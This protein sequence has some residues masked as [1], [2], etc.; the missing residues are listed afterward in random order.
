MLP[1]RGGLGDSDLPACL[2]AMACG[3]PGRPLGDESDQSRPGPEAARRGRRLLDARPSPAIAGDPRQPAGLV[4][5]AVR[6]QPPQGRGSPLPGPLSRGPQAAGDRRVPR[7]G[8]TRVALA[9]GWCYKRTNRLAQAIDSLNGHSR[10][11]RRGHAA[12]Q[13]GVLLEPGRQRLQGLDALTTAL[14]LDPD[15]RS[16]I[17]EESDFDQLRGN[18][19]FDRLIWPRTADLMPGGRPLHRQMTR[20]H[21]AIGGSAIRP[22]A[23]ATIPRPARGSVSARAGPVNLVEDPAG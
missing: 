5:H 6:G 16:L 22:T 4:D 2:V 13:S 18:P 9:L 11:P 15:L 3:P 10:A 12:L 21:S 7:P 14:D 23:S 17:A 8:D 1:D 19:E 20:A